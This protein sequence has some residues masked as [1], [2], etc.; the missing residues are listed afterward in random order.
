MRGTYRHSDNRRRTLFLPRGGLV[1]PF[2]KSYTGAVCD[3]LMMVEV[4]VMNRRALRIQ[5]IAMIVTY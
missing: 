1:W 5:S 3:H 2:R 4:L